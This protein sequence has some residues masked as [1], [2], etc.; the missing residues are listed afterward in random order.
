MK[1]IFKITKDPERARSLF[2]LTIDRLDIIKILPLDKTFK[3]VEEYYEV[4]KGFLTS[5]MYLDGYKTLSHKTLIEYF[6]NEYEILDESQIK[7]V[8]KLRKFRN[9]TLYYGENI[10]KDFLI[11]NKKE[12]K[13][14]INILTKFVRNKL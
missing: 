11:N 7:L 10:N 2:D 8:D 9:G 13:E 3:I 5:I 14:I 1:D 6:Q 4:I 12:I